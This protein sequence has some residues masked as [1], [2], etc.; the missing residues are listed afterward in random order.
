MKPYTLQRVAFPAPRWE[1]GRAARQRSATPNV[2]QQRNGGSIR[3]GV[4]VRKWLAV[5][6]APGMAPAATAVKYGPGE[7][8]RRQRGGEQ[9]QAIAGASRR[10][11]SLLPEGV[12]GSSA[13][14]VNAAVRRVLQFQAATLTKRTYSVLRLRDVQT[15]QPCVRQVSFRTAGTRI[16]HAA[17]GGGVAA[18]MCVARHSGSRV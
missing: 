6:A 15:Q 14:R 12:P 17:P 2:R 10:G 8:V 18:Y 1:A 5:G 7:Q 9:W 11:A 13:A 3:E 4:S 16:V